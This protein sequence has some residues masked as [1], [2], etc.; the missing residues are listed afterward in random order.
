MGAGGAFWRKVV[1]EGLSEEVTLELKQK[2]P[3]GIDRAQG[4]THQVQR[5]G[6]STYKGPEAQ[7]NWCS[8]NNEKAD[9]AGI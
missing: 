8:R 3:S 7:M 9:V 6:N 2:E 4:R 5:K 1:R